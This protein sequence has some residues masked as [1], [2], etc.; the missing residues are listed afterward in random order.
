[1]VPLPLAAGISHGAG[2]L[3][4][5]NDLPVIVADLQAARAVV[6]DVSVMLA[7]LIHD[8]PACRGLGLLP[9]PARPAAVAALALQATI[10]CGGSPDTP[11]IY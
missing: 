9:A 7:M 11:G 3:D 8:R 5:S 2:A 10:C 4:I 1:M 6:V